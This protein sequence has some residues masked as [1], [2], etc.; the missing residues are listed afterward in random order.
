VIATLALGLA[1]TL[2]LPQASPIPVATESA[3]LPP[4]ATSAPAE[5][6]PP[7]ATPTAAPKA[8]ATLAPE[9]YGYRFVP[10]LPANPAPG[11][12]LIFA[13]YM[14]AKHLHSHGPIVIRVETSDS[15]IGVET[16]SNGHG[17][18]IPQ[19][20]PG[21]YYAISTLPAIPFI[22]AGMS[23][24]LIFVAH[25]ADGRQFVVRV[26]VELG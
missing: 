13:V 5:S 10:H 14:N 18:P 3:A 6:A 8:T 2:A 7:L 23:T 22:A 26:P 1:T 4:A 9:A 19:V 16:K 20:A 15:V 24:D 12:P 25:S 21:V 11:Q 17:G